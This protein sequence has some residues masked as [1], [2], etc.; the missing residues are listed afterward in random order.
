MSEADLAKIFRHMLLGVFHT[1]VADSVRILQ[2]QRGVGIPT[3]AENRKTNQLPGETQQ[4]LCL[5]NSLVQ[6]FRNVALCKSRPTDQESRKEHISA[7]IA[8]ESNMKT[9]STT[10]TTTAYVCI[11]S[12]SPCLSA[13]AAAPAALAERTVYDMQNHQVSADG[14]QSF[15]LLFQDAIRKSASSTGTSSAG[16]GRACS[17]CSACRQIPWTVSTKA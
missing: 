15:Y 14:F 3:T 17:K 2:P 8:T 1:H 10:V 11:Y 6:D 4:E 9:T 7:T 16:P 12:I 5:I 13:A